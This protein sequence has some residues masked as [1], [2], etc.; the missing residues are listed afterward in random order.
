MNELEKLFNKNIQ[1]P[2][3]NKIIKKFEVRTMLRASAIA[4]LIVYPSDVGFPS[5][6]KRSR[7]VALRS[8]GLS[9]PSSVQYP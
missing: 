8:T 4:S 3:N 1:T 7:S 6:R 5:V 9:P 2:Q